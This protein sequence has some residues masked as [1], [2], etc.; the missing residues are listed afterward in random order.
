MKRCSMCNR[1]KPRTDFYEKNKVAKDGRPYLS[2]YC[3]RCTSLRNKLPGV[4]MEQINDPIH[5]INK[6]QVIRVGSTVSIYDK[7]AI[8]WAVRSL[9]TWI[10][11]E[12]NTS[13]R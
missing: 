7:E 6:L 10:L 3:K 13:R 8:D 4:H 2:S 5:W 12:G 9:G 1:D 11:S